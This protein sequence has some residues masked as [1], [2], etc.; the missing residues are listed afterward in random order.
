MKQSFRGKIQTKNFFFP[1]PDQRGNL[2][3]RKFDAKNVSSIC[4]HGSRDSFVNALIPRCRPCVLCLGTVELISKRSSCHDE[5][6]RSRP[7]QTKQFLNCQLMV[8]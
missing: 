5:K 3:C 7:P 1:L 8:E 4:Q 2:R 6:Q